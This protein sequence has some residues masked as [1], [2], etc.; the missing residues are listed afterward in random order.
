[1]T[2]I[3][4]G[5]QQ[6]EVGIIPKDWDVKE[7]ENIAIL[8][9]GKFSARPRNDP[10]FFGGDIPFIQTGDV[11]KSNGL[12]TTYTQTLNYQGLR[13]SKLFP[14]KTLFFT[15]AANIGDVGIAL[16]ETACPD[17]LIAITPKSKIEKKWIFYALKSR[18]KE[19][20][21]LAT[22]NTQ[23]NINLEKLKPYLLPV[24]P[25]SEQK[26]IAQALSDVDAAIAELDRLTTKKRNIKQ[27]AMQQLLT[28]KK[29][30]PDFS[31]EWEVKKL[32]EVSQLSSGTTPSRNMK[33]RYYLG[34]NINWV[35]TT[36]LNNGDINNTEEKITELALDETCLRKYDI[37]TVLVAMY[38]GFNQIGRTGLLKIEATVNQALIAIQPQHQTLNS[39]FLI[40][41][42]NF[43][44]D[45]WK[46]VAISSRK[47]PNITSRDVKNFSI[48]LPSIP[49]Q[50]AIAQVLSDMDTEIEA[51]E[52]KR[53]KY[54]AIK[55]GMMQELL[56]GR[57]RLI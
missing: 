24:P 35:K 4:E 16:F 33:N 14:S 8:E 32:E 44:V 53:H 34:G 52:Q 46:N 12:I 2:E 3:A 47:D 42:L 11:T 18:K 36:D 7:L 40:N 1:M 15:I 28:G 29:R 57:T 56:T 55:Q 6:T 22:Q 38:G 39:T 51:L 25:I 50:K 13:V 10:K 31:G 5:Y 20:E 43:K 48:S 49:E 54:K 37:G 45:Y 26:A 30:L 27:G 21:S 41:Y 19:F 17:S 9:R 23:L